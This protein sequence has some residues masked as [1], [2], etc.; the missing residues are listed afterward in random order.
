M[1]V[2]CAIMCI[3]LAS[4]K[5]GCTHCAQSSVNKKC[6]QLMTK[7]LCKKY[8]YLILT[9]LME[10]LNTLRIRVARVRVKLS[11]ASLREI[12]LTSIEHVFILSREG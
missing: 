7:I 10:S 3:Q 9:G 12:T 1:F 5:A 8:T 4:E 6:I 11:F 2:I